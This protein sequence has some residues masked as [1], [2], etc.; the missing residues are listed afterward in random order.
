VTNHILYNEY[1]I[2]NQFTDLINAC[3]SHELRNPLNA[4][5]AKNIE[6]AALYNELVEILE[7]CSHNHKLYKCMQI[8]EKLKEG[9]QVQ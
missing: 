3:V 8:I 9:R 1:K 6:K 5:I 2:K 7:T 4:I